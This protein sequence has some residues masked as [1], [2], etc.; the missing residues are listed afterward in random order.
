[1]SSDLSCGSSGCFD[2]RFDAIWHGSV[3]Q[4]ISECFHQVKETRD[5]A[6]VGKQNTDV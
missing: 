3:K 4:N 1:V 2:K 5:S 6:S